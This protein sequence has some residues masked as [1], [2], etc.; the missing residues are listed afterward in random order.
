[1]AMALRKTTKVVALC[2][3]LLGV[4]VVL[5]LRHTPVGCSILGGRWGTVHSTCVPPFC[6]Y[7]GACG[8]WVYPMIPCGAIPAGTS[9]SA[10]HF[11]LGD[12]E[13][14]QGERYRWDFGK[15]DHLPVQA[16]IRDGRLASLSCP[17]GA[18]Y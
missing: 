8:K 2:L 15:Q 16:L 13:E 4:A 18:R 7:M 12:P 11:L 9:Y 3:G 14:V 1:M 17:P 6:H 10:V 5:F